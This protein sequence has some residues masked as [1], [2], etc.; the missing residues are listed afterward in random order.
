MTQRV[1]QVAATLKRTLQDVL[2]RGLAD[3]RVRG[4]IT[5]TRIDV[6]SDLADAIVFCTVTPDEFEELNM[7]GVS[8]ASGWIRREAASRMRL[9]RMPR[10]QFKIDKQLRRQQETLAAINEA[11]RL[12]EERAREKTEE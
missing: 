8:S 5:V 1:D 12:D 7:H 2:A 4:L 11:S 9:R 6:T 3:P 10:L